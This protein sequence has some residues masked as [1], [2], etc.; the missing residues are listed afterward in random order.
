MNFCGIVTSSRHCGQ[1]LRSCPMCGKEAFHSLES[2]NEWLTLFFLPVVPLGWGRSMTRCNLCGHEGIEGGGHAVMTHVQAGT[3]T[4]PECAELVK[5]EARRCRYCRYSFSDEEITAVRQRVE[6][7]ATERAE[8]IARRS[9]L[10]K[11]R[12][13]SILSWLIVPPAA[14]LSV[15]VVVVV[16]RV[17]IGLGKPDESVWAMMVIWGVLSLPLVL[18]LSFRRKARRIRSG[19]QEPTTDTE[20]DLWGRSPSS[21]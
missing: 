8:L 13:Y 11:A 6:T 19:L 18:G 7:A 9:L 15:F 21:N 4:C 20:D 2:R 10:R 1:A 14:L 12:V 5:L 16:V 3:K 17:A